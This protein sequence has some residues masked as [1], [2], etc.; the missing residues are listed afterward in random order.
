MGISQ[1]K[2]KQLLVYMLKN[3]EKYI[4]SQ[5]DILDL[6]Q[7][8]GNLTILFNGGKTSYLGFGRAK[9]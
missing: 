3:K 9:T 2:K 1:G 7:L 4:F 6:L 8:N 5:S